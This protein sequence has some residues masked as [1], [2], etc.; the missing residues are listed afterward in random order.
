MIRLN[1]LKNV[2]LY[3]RWGAVAAGSIAGVLAFLLKWKSSDFV[4]IRQ[5]L[6]AVNE[7]YVWITIPAFT[8]IAGILTF[9]KTHFGT[10]NSWKV[11]THLLEEYRKAIFQS[12]STLENEADHHNRVTLY[13]H[14]S[15]RLAFC[16]WPWSNWVVPV[17]RTGHTTQNWRIPRFLAPTGEPDLAEGVA[18]LTFANNSTII[19]S[20]LPAL[21]PESSDTAIQRYAR[22]GLVS[23]KWVRNRLKRGSCSIRSLVGIPIEVDGKPWGAIVVDSRNPEPIIGIKELENEEFKRLA[24]SL[25]KL[26][27]N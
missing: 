11:A 4:G 26:L 10:A 25:S 19:V 8:A 18:G 15:M 20:K 23:E 1:W 13:K 2:E 16:R 22:K 7:A 12:K 27:E 3:L 21:T 9:F 6:L 5:E 24:R 14:V 17:A